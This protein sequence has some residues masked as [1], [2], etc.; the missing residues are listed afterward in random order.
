MPNLVLQPLVENAIKHGVSARESGATIEVRAWRDGD[1]LHLSVL[2]NGPGIP[3]ENGSHTTGIGLRNTK[4]RLRSLYGE[5]Y[6][7][8]LE[9]REEGGVDAHIILPYHTS[10]DLYTISVRDEDEE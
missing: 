9:E 2:D 6:Q 3:T 1:W 7:F 5:T 10:D 8:M 4:D